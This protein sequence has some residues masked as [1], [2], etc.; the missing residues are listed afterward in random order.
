MKTSHTHSARTSLSGLIA[1]AAN[2]KIAKD[3]THAQRNFIL[4]TLIHKTPVFAIALLI[5]NLFFALQSFGQTVLVNPTSPWTVPAEVTSAKVEVWGSGGGGGSA[6]SN[7]G[8]TYGGGGGGGGAYQVGNLTVSGG[9]TYTISVG[10]AGTAGSSSNGGNGNPSSVSGAG[11]AVTANGGSGGGR[12]N[13]AYG[14]G[15]SAG[16]GGF[17]N[18][19]VGGTSTGN[20]AGG[21]GGAGNATPTTTGAGGAGGNATTG[22]AGTGNPN[23][24]PYQGGA[25]G[26]F[27][28]STG[29]GNA[30]S[31][32]APG[33]GG[34]GGR[35]SR[36]QNNGGGAGGAGQ[37][38]ITFTCPTYTISSSTTASWC[39]GVSNFYTATSATA[40]LTYSWS[41]AAVTGITPSTGSGSSAT[42]TETLI[43][44][45]SNP[46]N[47]VYVYTLT[48]GS[49]SN[50][51]SVTVTVN[52]K[53]TVS[54]SPQSVCSGG[55]TTAVT[56]VS[57]PVGATFNWSSSA[58][59]GISGNTA[60]GTGDIP[61]QTLT[62]TASIAGTV[63]YTII[64]TLNS[65]QGTS[66]TFVVTVNP[67]PLA[68]TA[69]ATASTVCS[70]SSTTI[71]LASSIGTIQWQ[72]STDGISGWTD[73]TT[74]TGG[75]TATYTTLGL[76][77]KTY[78]QA[79]VNGAC[80]A[81]YS[82]V[83]SV[84]VNLAA[85]VNAGVDQ[86]V[87]SASPTVILAGVIGG[88]ATGATWSG[89]T[90]TFSP[91]NTTL[92]A[93][94]NPSAAEIL[95]G[96][97]ITLTLTTDDP[98]GI[99]PAV[100]DQMIIS[101]NLVATANAGIDQTICSSSTPVS[102][103][104]TRGG[105]GV[106]SST[107][108]TSGTGTF[109]QANN[110]ST[111]YT[112][113]AGDKTAGTVTLTLTT[114]DPTGPCGAATDQ[115]VITIDQAATVNA[116][117]DQTVCSA[118][119]AV[120]LAGVTGG[121][122]TG[123]T[124]S[125]GAGTFSPDNTTL[126]ATYNPS[127]AEILAGG[128]ITLTLTTDDPAGIC[129]AVSD[130][131]II[132]INL[133][134]T[135][136]AGID[137]T[138]CSSST[139]VSITGTRGGTGVTSSTWTTSGTG[140]FA[141]AT[142]L[143]TTYTPSAG[144][145]AAGAV[146]LT[147]TTND[148]TGPCGAA[149]DQMVI[150]INPAASV[151]AGVDQTVCSAS[152]TVVLAGVI[153]GGATG[154]T[155][156]G[157]G[158]TFSPNNTA[159]NASYTPTA[160]EIS[161]GTV[162]LTLTT[163]DPAGICGAVSDATVITIKASPTITSAIASP[164][165]LCLG[166]SSN[167]VVTAPASGA[168]TIVNYDF[169]GGTSFATLS[170]ALASGITCSAT[171][172]AAFVTATGNVTTA[173]TP[174]AFT[175]NSTAGSAL[176]SALSNSWTFTLGGTS[177][178]L[179]N[180]FKV[181]AQTVRTS[182]G[183]TTTITLSYALNG[184][185][186]FVTTGITSGTWSC[187]S[188]GTWVSNIATLPVAVDNPTT[189]IAFR[190]TIGTTGGTP[191]LLDNFQVQAVMANSYSWTATPSGAS[192]GLTGTAGSALTTNNNITVSPT[193]TTNYV[194]S[195]TGSNGCPNTS[196]VTV[197]VNT[198]P[199]VTSTIKKSYKG[200]DLSCATSADGE[201]TV[202][203]SGTGTLQY[204]K[205][206]G[207][208]YQSG[209]VF[210]NLA[211]GSYPIVVKDGS[212]CPSS[213]SPVVITAPAA[214]TVVSKNVSSPI[215]CYGGTATVTL[216]AG[217]G[218]TPY[219]YTFNGETNETGTFSG[220][221][222]GTGKGFSI[223]D[224]NNCTA[225][226]TIDVSQPNAIVT[227]LTGNQSICNGETTNITL[228]S[229]TATSFV[230]TAILHSGAATGF[231]D[232]SGSNIIQSLTNSGS[233]D[234]VIRYTVTGSTNICTGETLIIDVT[235]KPTPV[236]TVNNSI[237]G[238][239]E[240][241]LLT[242]VTNTNGTL[243]YYGLSNELL[244][245]QTVNSPG[246]YHIRATLGTCFTEQ[247]VQVTVNT[248]P[249]I[250]LVS[251]NATICQGIISAELPFTST[252]GDK[253]SIV[254]DSEA[255][256][257]GFIDFVAYSDIP[258][259][260][261]PLSLTL[262][263]PFDASAKTYNGTL[264]IINSSTGCISVAIPITITVKP[265][266]I[267]TNMVA[268]ACSGVAIGK[269]LPSVDNHSVPMTVTQY[270]IL[271]F[272]NG[273]SNQTHQS[274][275]TF[276]SLTV[277]SLV[278][279]IKD[280][281][282]YSGLSY[283]DV[284][285]YQ[286]TPYAGACAGTSIFLDVTINPVP[287]APTAFNYSGTYDG[288]PHTASATAPSG[289][290]L[291][292][293]TTANG[294]GETVAPSGTNV[295]T[296]TAWA[297]SVI[298][299]TGCVSASRTEVTVT[300]TQAD[301]VIHVTPYSVAY[302]GAPHTSDYTAVGVESPTPA[303]L[304]GLMTVSGTTHTASGT[305]TGDAWS[306]AGN[307]NYKAT[308]GTVN[309]AIGKINATIN[310]T[311]FSGTYDGAAHGAT[312]T[313]TGLG[314][315]ILAGLDLGN[316]FTNVPGGTA[317]WKFTDLTGNYNDATGITAII[318]SRAT[319]SISITGGTFTY[320]ASAHAASGFA[321][322]VG[323]I[324]D[325]L[326][327][328]VT[329]SY[330]GVLPTVY[331]A[332][333]VAPTNAGTYE[334]TASF[335]GNGNYNP[336]SNTASITINKAV[337]N[338]VWSNPSAISFGTALG[339][340]QLNA[341]VTGVTG[342]TA[343]GAETYTPG[344]GTILN[345]G[346]NQNLR[347][348]V[349]ATA[350]YEA[351]TKTVQIN[352]DQKTLEIKAASFNK[353]VGSLY[354]FIGN[355]F[356]T[357]G[358]VNGNTVTSVI[359]SST[360][361]AAIA[362]VGSYDILIS[363][364]IGS[365]LGNY[366]ITYTEGVLNVQDT[367][368]PDAQ[369]KSAIVQLDAFGNGKIVVADINN[370]STDD[371][372]IQSMILSK[373]DFTCADI[374]TNPN[375][376]TLTVTDNYGHVSICTTSVTVEDKVIPQIVSGCP[377]AITAYTSSDCGQN[378]ELTSIVVSDNC[379]P[380]TMSV[381]VGGTII[382]SSLP[383][384]HFF[385][386]GSSTVT[387]TVTD[388]HGNSNYCIFNVTVEDIT[389][390]TITCKSDINVCTGVPVTIVPPDATDNC[391][392]KSNSMT[393]VRSDHLALDAAYPVGS[394]T[395]TWTVSDVHNNLNTCTQTVTV[396]PSPTVNDPADQVV[397]N[398]T[399]T[400]MVT[401]TGALSGTM[402]N[403]VNDNTGIGL[404]ASGTGPIPSF[405]SDNSTATPQVATVTVTPVNNGCSGLP[406]SF[407]IT[408]NPTPVVNVISNLT[409]CKNGAASA[410]AFSSP[411]TGGTV[412]YNWTSTIDVGFGLSGA[413]V[414]PAFTATNNSI[415]PV[416]ATVSVK[417]TI[418]GCTG[419][420]TTFTVTVIPVPSAGIISGPSTVCKNTTI[421]LN[422]NG[423]MG[424]VWSSGNQSIATVD[425]VSGVVT[426]V[427]AGSPTIFYTVTSICGSSTAS[428][429]ITVN[430]GANPGT[431]TNLYTGSSGP[432]S[433]CVNS[434]ILL[435]SSGDT[436]GTWFSFNPAVATVNSANG[437]VTGVSTGTAQIVYMITGTCGTDAAFHTVNVN[438]AQNAGVISGPNTVCA[439]STILLSSSVGNT[440]GIWNS[441][442]PAA[443]TVDQSGVVTG[444][445]AGNSTITFT[446]TNG[447]GIATTTFNVTVNPAPNAGTL[448]GST[449][450][451]IGLTDIYS[452]NG[453]SGGSWLS[454]NTSVATVNSSTGVVTTVGAG[455][456]NITYTVNSGCG[457][458]VSSIKTLTVS[459][460][461]TAGTISGTSP[462]CITIT[463][464]Y[465][466]NGTSGGSWSS[467]NTGVATIDPSTGLVTAVGAGTTDIKYEVVSGC[468]APVSTIKPLTVSPNVTAGTVSGTSPLCISVTASYTSDGT[469]GGSWSSSN[470][471]VATVNPTTGL[472]T[473]VGAGTT[474][475]TYKVSS[476][477][478]APVSSTKTLTVNPNVTAG[479]VSGTSPLCIGTT[480][481]YTSN[482]TS[483]G[484][485]SS[486]NIGVATVNASTGMVTAIG[487]GTTDIKYEVGSGC[488]SPVS[489]IKTLTVSPNV[490]AGTVSGTSPLC[491][492][493]T[494]SYTSD[495]TFGGSWS[496]SST[497]VA[498]VNPTTG[499]V[500]AVGAGTTDIKYEV[501]SGCGSPVSSIKTLTVSP[502]VTAGTVSGTSPLCISA[503]ASYTSDGTSGGSWSSSSTGVAT[504]N[505]TTGLVT[506]VGAGT[507]D[508]TYLVSSGCGSPVSS[509][510]T[511]TVSPNVTAGTV[512]G[513]SPLCISATA[514][515]TSNGT[516]GGSWSSSN[517]G[518]ATVDPS[519]GLVT[520]VGAG[521]TDIKYEVGSGCGAPV[522]TIKTLTVNP[523]V[524]AGT[525]S[526]A[527]P[528]C[529]SAT[530]SYISDG[531]SGGS[532]SSSNTGVATVNPTTG[533]VT[534]IGAGTTD[535]KY[536][537]GSGCGSPVS[538]IKTLT[539]YPR[540]QL[541][542]TINA[543]TVTD[544]NDGINDLGAISVCNSSA[545]NLSFTQIADLNS[546]TPSNLVKVIQQFTRTNVTF[547]PVDA[548]APIGAY[549][550][551]F[552]RNVSLVNA[553]QPGTLEM[554]LR[555]FYDANN[556]DLLDVD[557]CAG[558]WI[559]YTVN[560]NTA[561]PVSVVVT[562]SAN[563][564][565]AGSSV[566][567]TATPTNG[568]SVPAFQWKVNGNNAGTNSS[569][570][571]YIPLN[572]DV[573]T[574]I[575]NSSLAC[576]SANP[577]TSIPVTMTVNQLLPVSVSVS[578][579]AN[580]ICAVTP[581]IFTATPTNE[582]TT[583]AYQWK[584]NGNNAGTNSNILSYTPLNGD[585][586]TVVL[587]SSLTCVS[588][589]PATSSPVTMN[590]NPVLPVSVSVSPSAN[591]VCAG[592]LVTFT[593]TPTNGGVPV[594]S[595]FV[596]NL[597]VQ[598]AT[599]ATYS[600]APSNNDQV[601]VVMT[602]SETCK[603]GSP[604][605]SNIVNM[606]VN[607]S[608]PVSILIGA[609]ANSV[610]AG[611]PVLFIAYA[612]NGGTTPSYQWK[613]NG[614]SVGSNGS[615]YGYTPVNGD[616]V[617][618]VVTSNAPCVSGNP[619]LSNA[620]TMVV[621][622][623][624]VASVSNGVSQNNVCSGTLVTFT[625]TPT[626]GGSAPVYQWYKGATPVG[627]NAATY[628]YLPSDGDVISVVMTSNATPCLSGSPATSNSV[629]MIVNPVLTAGVS[630]SANA[631]NVCA[632]T[633]V[634]FTATPVGGGTT[635]T[636]QWYKNSVAVATSATYNYI[637]INGDV[638][639]V[640]M[641]SNAP[642]VSGSP[643]TSNSVTMVVNPVVA[644][645]VSIGVSQNN[646]CAGTTATF[647]ATPV[648]GGTTPTYQWYK[649]SVAVS[650]GA[651]YSYTPVNGDVVY[652]MM[653][654]N[655]PCASGNPATSGSITMV[656]N[657]AVAASVSIVASQ[658]NV[659]TGTSVTFTATPVGG[660]TT[661]T[662][663]WYKNSAAVGTSSTYTYAP[664]NGDV[665]YVR[666]TSNAT[667]CLSGSPATSNSVVMIVNPLPN[668]S[669]G[670]YGPVCTDAADITLVGSPAGG[671]WSGIGVNGNLFDPSVGTQTLS[672]TYTNVS[673]C[674]KIV[675]TTITV[676]QSPAAPIIT[677]TQPTCVLPT[678]TIAV[679]S[680]TGTG[681]TYSINGT[682]YTNT[683][684]IFTQVATGSY[685]VTAK[686]AA[687]CIS[688][689]TNVAIDVQAGAP[690]APTVVL[691][692][693]TCT[694]STGTIT[695]TAPKATGM[696][697]SINGINYSNTSGIF[698]LIA[699]GTYNVTA[700]SA[701]GCI[702]ALTNVIIITQPTAPTNMSRGAITQ[703]TCSVPTGSMVINGLPAGTWTIN[704]GAI[705]GTGSSTTVTG[706]VPGTYNFTITNEAGCTSVP[707]NDVVINAV[708]GAPSAPVVSIVQ[709]NCSVTTGTITVT[710]PLGA[711]LTYS[712]NGTTY[713][714]GTSFSG[715]APGSYT[716]RVRNSAGCISAGTNVTINVLPPALTVS[717]TA[718][719]ITTFGGTTTLT[720]NATGGTSPYS[721]SLNGVTFQSSNTFTISA[722]TF[723]VSVIDANGCTATSAAV[724]VTQPGQGTLTTTL[725]Y[726]G[727]QT[728]QYGS[729]VSLAAGLRVGNAVVSGRT[730]T[731]TIGTQSVTATT[732]NNGNASA[733]LVINQAPGTGYHVYASFAGD[734][735]YRSSS[736]NT[737][738]FTI[739][740]RSV[741]AS[742]TGSVSKVYDGNALATLSPA[743]YVL[744]GIVFGDAVTLNNPTTGS[745]NNRNVG[746]G[747]RVTVN[748]L[749]LSGAR[750]GWYILTS[751]SA[752]ANIGTIT[753]VTAALRNS[754]NIKAA[755]IVTDTPIVPTIALK[756]YPNP[757][758][759]PVTFDFSVSINAKVTLDIFAMSGQR[760]ARIFD[761]DVEAD[762]AQTV[763]FD[764]SLPSGV[765][766]YVLKWNDQVVT[767]KFVKTK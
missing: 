127:A 646:I 26:A 107:W 498:T 256:A 258:V 755:I 402:F 441:N 52:P 94:Y 465:T 119:P 645:S 408:V 467:S 567:F 361:A 143:N 197:T 83:V 746:T 388:S 555:T 729:S 201:I 265:A 145:K 598:G 48:S 493:T 322:G 385:P 734:G 535:I 489:S 221:L 191:V 32:T 486:S 220:V 752:N 712:I 35:A 303:D 75:N 435:R 11:G 98:A 542:T 96:G 65:C 664:V 152:P 536:E 393:G 529:I 735:T 586:V 609:T 640:R 475:I 490:T 138:I 625:A 561:L 632:G 182:T 661:P 151:N 379:G 16:T 562:P 663:Q 278:N 399:S 249:T 702:S 181:Y 423:N 41:R 447:C 714:A 209:N 510:K 131:M 112:P 559:V 240:V 580:P 727:G 163:D 328:V 309:N 282:L 92:S 581:V 111:T 247:P 406:Q 370:G 45:T 630:I 360:G 405:T 453:T 113:S 477:C 481:S 166:G 487:A 653:T 386:V 44:S 685:N 289:S 635:P 252:T 202:A 760:I 15:G 526:G 704:P 593:A 374:A 400:T 446:A 30:A 23:F 654:S 601:K 711:G 324:S 315:E 287:A 144:D 118:S 104:G 618:C 577:A 80:P 731:F 403:W 369:C 439:G 326:A 5:V 491:I 426:G 133:V 560:V 454:T 427:S 596:N 622:P 162:T 149:T 337:Q 186:T 615:T 505:P 691:V 428:F 7:S 269:E 294:N 293:Y 257:A 169:N 241:N 557:E 677:L 538:S 204:S 277:P 159:L 121:S 431:I 396:K 462:L 527:S 533:L 114:N 766:V 47:V 412:T 612:T 270:D 199:T 230:W 717:G 534:A 3:I 338:I 189:S 571:S 380:T 745:Y 546:I 459:P 478:T 4:K 451:C 6:N 566:T 13:G 29:T 286:I 316:E 141:L 681:M 700:K 102:I 670:T 432:S 340:A 81:V 470:T 357:N 116:G 222:A 554:K 674:V 692:Q 233:V 21:G 308:S 409:Y 218:T 89:G 523:N 732:N 414:I 354:T 588:G 655:A 180:T 376:V 587:S 502:N 397:C 668:V 86:T 544:N 433:V 373:Y 410:I 675:T 171:G 718:G 140:T 633:S 476:G 519:T 274:T 381:S 106:T 155:W 440:A 748:G 194:V 708:P 190:L 350:N 551:A 103:A 154:A 150:T 320:D 353:E 515:Y 572:S 153:G 660:G 699:S 242:A 541:Q 183:G 368:A 55:S 84:T 139:I 46:I 753:A 205:D 757:S 540:P 648:G 590:V 623:V 74:G 226:G 539:V 172:T 430:P 53:I 532:W 602:S 471:G 429:T 669:A 595:W 613:V 407:T 290:S 624:I 583:P 176:S 77:T 267:L 9:Q 164:T 56:L 382:G 411:T 603:S 680:P 401:F 156:S 50:T 57:T 682:S 464:S 662:Y 210:S 329:F 64:P 543:A 27:I 70:G 742:L 33:G 628:S 235:V 271:D 738:N 565:C 496:S 43:N 325:V 509:T 530:A 743:N 99:C 36:N 616:I 300:I 726:T 175:T 283:G 443:A 196:N 206:N 701:G 720:A 123:A 130:Q 492:S 569:S 126:N 721:Y 187:T 688:A 448:G 508:I 684:G 512:N 208:S 331:A 236:L 728:V 606:T 302:D 521:T 347:I 576:A 359:I 12:G 455:T 575:L 750:A 275:G 531:T 617:T 136:N 758:S 20:G 25:G 450:L 211:A 747:K 124:W 599:G 31:N 548:I 706:L 234:A 574:V 698:T 658:N 719:T 518:V 358:L 389:L 310:V 335:A 243:S 177:L 468:G 34:G 68:G 722:G 759:G 626:N 578:P 170:P 28:T 260:P 227:T 174:A 129:P 296:Y 739:T 522:S 319:A 348:D 323:G 317:T 367:Q 298:S 146:T 649:N 288:T 60:S 413:G 184:S 352:V 333:S 592:S 513:T 272:T 474:D 173:T 82:N 659:C 472:V 212:L 334:V 749:A 761:A 305:Y 330:K 87:C 713:Q 391:G 631:N 507:T 135:A 110:L 642:C 345:A 198:P 105:T 480:D 741:T 95:A 610:C 683:T 238:C 63:T 503:T 364:A 484:N 651:T 460:N 678:G 342:G 672:Y 724:V 494:A 584:V 134:A 19:G 24:S 237:S 639:Y 137:Q 629:V 417:A 754:S 703:P 425:P 673:G 229:T 355:E 125:G 299:N 216:T 285:T 161:T 339:S 679:S 666:M 383:L 97:N 213:A 66:G 132:S 314:N 295:G 716:A 511:L 762:V 264:T 336:A 501:G 366:N 147:L 192:A 545:D 558:D 228:N 525:V 550:P 245:N 279:A 185:T 563:Q 375:P 415:S 763:V 2:G 255:H 79:K 627:T 765:Y 160:G 607:P 516:S 343:T 419:P 128:N 693:P 157:G 723:T 421:V 573:V 520:A 38:V 582:G 178:P 715:L 524:T 284:V 239:A 556:N 356:S 605:T 600:Y 676:N 634:T 514:S 195:M 158:G 597:V 485:W 638:V 344:S 332:T 301:A 528:L 392:I 17:N 579:S 570:F 689:G 696:T 671:V 224:A 244:S 697:Y 250:D 22:T 424:G 349:D 18:G 504:V 232:G 657:P 568:G 461:V 223:T 58:T 589:N 466:S 418:S 695:V 346:L 254:F 142:N 327:P 549:T 91:D 71:T 665:V 10:T 751:N 469:S 88:S 292:Y 637:P 281:V 449:P 78:Y 445:S 76:T 656:V 217:G 452:S 458:P 404:A 261:D 297:E 705:S 341:V 500:T 165:S 547:G 594:Y 619:A 394:T 764:K 479:T 62:T 644:A 767:G 378:V 363:G 179:C 100:S 725:S 553:A 641:T 483:G 585:V 614:T 591:S 457:S 168:T 444:V 482:G 246:L 8:T 438:A 564:V 395:I 420:A 506:A 442:T 313:A 148:P 51:Q 434:L 263:T 219:S 387:Y 280:D 709:P 667:P 122:A 49:C 14:T 69:T 690:V 707:S 371:G 276:T 737:H 390:P 372:G 351:A 101:I 193:V 306:F 73:V 321:Y 115:M 266:P 214:L 416:I 422:T 497:G 120:I 215:T 93:T 552:S 643:A 291:K 72:Q 259:F 39:S 85:T 318:I 248:L 54:A 273:G 67:L 262:P 365:G 436:G 488:G 203:A 647:T 398:N 636:Y 650:T 495:G 377:T 108:I 517:T 652:V 736:D 473:A 268:N 188:N 90:G 304:T 40:G 537:V 167:L 61:V 207:N 231:S 730:I 117:V 384:T 744:S 225:N 608:L 686:N 37:V 611:T 311:P 362:G 456:T 1:F 307:T 109:A 437:L 42:A 59:A 621:N 687:G 740:R 756:V 312:G 253:Y 499:L 710:S 620:V 463:A 251:A 200:S 733:T 694:V 604:A